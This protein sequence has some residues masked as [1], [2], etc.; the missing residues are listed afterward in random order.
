L[1]LA[2]ARAT[3]YL[4]AHPDEWLGKASEFGTPREVLK[5]AAGNRELAWEMDESFTAQAA[6]LGERMKALGVIERR[7]D[8]R[9]LFNTSFVERVKE[10][11]PVPPSTS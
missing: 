10:E 9:T 2:H 11:L 8:Y 7:P 6:A 4:K 5:R 1:V 3:E